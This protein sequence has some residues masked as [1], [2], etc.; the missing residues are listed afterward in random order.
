MDGQLDGHYGKISDHRVVAL[1]SQDKLS[2]GFN[3]QKS[4]RI[5]FD[6]ID[7]AQCSSSRWQMLS[8]FLKE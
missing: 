1:K 7:F 6:V 2:E 5:V 8:L 3:F 4:F